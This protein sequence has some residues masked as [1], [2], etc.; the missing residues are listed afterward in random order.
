MR[1]PMHFGAR[2]IL[3]EYAKQLREEKST[4]AERVLWKHL[5]S[6]KLQGYKFRFQH[7]F[8]NYIADFFCHEKRLVIEVDGGYHFEKEQIELDD[9][10]TEWLNERG[11][12]VIRFRNGEV[13]NDTKKVLEIILSNLTKED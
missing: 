1:K 7:P 2:S 13:L 5:K 6:R 10:R 11:I 3:F 9:A 4:E 12:K 8:G